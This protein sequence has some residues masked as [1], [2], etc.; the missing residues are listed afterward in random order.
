VPESE[1][2]ATATSLLIAEFTALRDQLQHLSTAGQAIVALHLTV[3]GSIAGIVLTDNAGNQLL[4]LVPAVASPLA[5]L[6]ADVAGRMRMTADYIDQHLRPIAV[7]YG[8]DDRLMRWEEF[9]VAREAKAGKIAPRGLAIWV[10]FPGASVAALV[11]A[12][13]GMTTGWLWVAWAVALVLVVFQSGVW[14]LHFGTSTWP[15]YLRRRR[16]AL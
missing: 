11:A 10:L 15:R 9:N 14:V 8:Q 7:E 5:L 4:L 3:V 13:G 2:R 1:S 12:V 6:Y 16:A